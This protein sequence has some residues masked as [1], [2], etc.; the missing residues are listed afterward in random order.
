[1]KISAGTRWL[2][3]SALGLASLAG[4]GGGGSVGAGFSFYAPIAPPPPR[5][6]TFGPA[7]G[8]GFVWID[9]YWGYRNGGY[10]WV[11]GRWERPPRRGSVWVSGGWER[12]GDR[13]GYRPGHWR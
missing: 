5:I 1:M 11:P 6:E 9:G 4:C 13:W 2:L 12:R 7:P 8:P 3:V 10:A